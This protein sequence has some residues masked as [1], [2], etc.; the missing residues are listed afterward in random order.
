LLRKHDL[1]EIS[2]VC[3][4]N[5]SEKIDGREGTAALTTKK[6]GREKSCPEGKIQAGG[7]TSETGG[8]KGKQT[9]TFCS[10]RAIIFEVDRDSSEGKSKGGR[11]R[12]RGRILFLK[13][14][15]V[16]KKTL[17]RPVG[18]SGKEEVF[19]WRNTGAAGDILS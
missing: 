16:I 4:L 8:K 19:C 1:P 11:S 6:E 12:L 10:E 13:A 7:T 2:E 15:A 18:L 17:S 3:G 9:S 14:A 5:E